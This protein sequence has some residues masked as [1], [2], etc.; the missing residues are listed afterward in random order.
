M[1]SIRIAE[2]ILELPMA[3]ERAESVAGDLRECDRCVFSCWHSVLATLVASVWNDFRSVWWKM[4]LTSLAL[5]L[6]WVFVEQRSIAP[7][8]PR[9]VACIC[10]STSH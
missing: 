5:D 10:G 8:L 1:H 9:S 3:H 2:W 6:I 4:M 7:V